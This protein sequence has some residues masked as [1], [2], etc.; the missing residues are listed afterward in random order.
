VEAQ[1]KYV[2]AAHFGDRLQV[3]ASL[4]EWHSR[5]VINYLVR[6]A[7][8][9]ERVARARTV[10]AVVEAASGTLQFTTPPVLL[11]RVQ[12]ALESAGSV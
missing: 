2:N 12:S 4:I 6:Q 5:L 8:T 11:D 3:R 10:Q 9:E 7:D 1:V